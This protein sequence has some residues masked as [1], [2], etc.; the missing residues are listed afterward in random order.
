MKLDFSPDWTILLLFI[1]LIQRLW[2]DLK[3]IKSGKEIRHGYH[4]A[5]SAMIMLAVSYLA[6]RLGNYHA[7]WQP[8]ALSVGIFGL[9]FDYALNILRGLNWYYIDD[10]PESS[11][12]DKQWS[13]AGV[14]GTLFIKL[15]VAGVCFSICYFSSYI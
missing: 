1:P 13:K 4:L 10:E 12:T 15:W 7:I 6:V 5:V 14:W 8:Y 3:T 11:W 9:F 2:W